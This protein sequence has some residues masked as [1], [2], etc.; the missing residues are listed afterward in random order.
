[1]KDTIRKNA[2]ELTDEQVERLLKFI[3]EGDPVAVEAKRKASE[4]QREHGEPV[5]TRN[6]VL[7]VETAQNIVA[8][9][10]EEW[11]EMEDAEKNDL[12]E[13]LCCLMVARDI[14]ADFFGIKTEGR[15][16]VVEE[17]AE[18]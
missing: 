3:D 17:G 12:A 18:E 15:L 11:D 2:P 10:F 5:C 14:V 9:D 13:L 8:A 1:M 4:W 16:E 6:I 7:A